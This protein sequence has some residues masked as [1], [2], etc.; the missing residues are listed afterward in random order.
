MSPVTNLSAIIIPTTILVTSDYSIHAV[1]S[2]VIVVCFFMILFN[3]FIFRQYQHI[4]IASMMM[5]IFSCILFIVPSSSE[6]T[7]G[8]KNICGNEN[9]SGDGNRI[10]KQLILKCVYI[11]HK[12]DQTLKIIFLTIGWSGIILYFIYYFYER[13]Y[14]QIT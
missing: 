4:M 2:T 14:D 3:I 12:N 9:S 5:F 1:L 6:C 13:R 10:C 7:D 11:T 8:Y